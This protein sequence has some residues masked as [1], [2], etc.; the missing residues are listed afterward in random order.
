MA[1]AKTSALPVV[2][3]LA[4]ADLLPV[5]ASGVSSAIAASDARTVMQDVLNAQNI[6]AARIF[7]R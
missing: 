6:I 4:D 2:T 1:D 7:G 3:T 5:V